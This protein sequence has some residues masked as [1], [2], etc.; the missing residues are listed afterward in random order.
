M[1][2]TLFSQVQLAFLASAAARPDG[3]ILPPDD[4]NEA[5]ACKAIAGLF[6]GKF[7]T[8]I[9]VADAALAWRFEGEKPLGV[10][11]TEQGSL[12]VAAI[13]SSIDAEVAP[14]SKIGRVITMLSAAKGASLAELRMCTGWQP[15]SVRAALA[16]LRRKGITIRLYRHAA[17]SFYRIETN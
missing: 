3:A 16:T 5:M 1:K 11:I 9:E 7:A 4:A 17:R 13:E 10:I 15:H 6:K 14:G 2:K 12:A 8:E